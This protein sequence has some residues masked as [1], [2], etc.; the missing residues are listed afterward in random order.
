[1][2][3]RSPDARHPPPHRIRAF[4]ASR[5]AGGKL[6]DNWLQPGGLYLTNYGNR[7]AAGATPLECRA[8]VQ[9]SPLLPTSTCDPKMLTT[10]EFIGPDTTNPNKTVIPKDRN[11]FGPAVGFSWNVPWFGA[12]KT[13]VRGGYSIQYQ[14]ISV[15]D[16]ILAPLDGG[17]TRNQLASI[18][19][20]DIA[21]IINGPNGRAIRY[22]DLPGLVP[23][24]PDVAPGVATPVYA[25]G[26][27]FG[28]NFS[29]TPLLQ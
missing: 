2:L 21:A 10:L 22:T 25:R 4:G 15:R 12:G 24:R 26:A 29:A 5:G 8:G 3:F 16:D 19:D 23:R 17:N 20:A 7:L 9:Q 14:R 28:M 11:N 1:M 18:F 13:T 27:S 6:F